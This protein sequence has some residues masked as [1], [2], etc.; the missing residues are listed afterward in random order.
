[1]VRFRTIPKS[2]ISWLLW[3]CS[4]KPPS[5]RYV[6]N[7]LQC[8]CIDNSW[9]VLCKALFDPVTAFESQAPL[10]TQLGASNSVPLYKLA[11]TPNSHTLAFPK[12]YKLHSLLHALFQTHP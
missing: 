4:R 1:M 5:Y 8:T 10:Q 3:K 12:L 6:A 7:L 11:T 9:A 2:A